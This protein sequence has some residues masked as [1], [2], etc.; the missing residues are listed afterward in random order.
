MGEGVHRCI[1][2]GL[3]RIQTAVAL[4]TLLTRRPDLEVRTDP[5]PEWNSYVGF[6]GLKSLTIAA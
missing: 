6:H 2:A 3:V 5:E 4:R 1:G